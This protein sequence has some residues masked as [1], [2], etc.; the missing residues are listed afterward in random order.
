QLQ[1]GQV[2]ENVTVNETTTPVQTSS[3]AQAGTITGTQVRELELNNRNF[4]QLV[5]LQPGVTSGLPD[6]V[7]F[8]ISNTSSVAV[9]G[10]RTGA[11][12]WTV[13][14][15]D[16]NDSGSNLTLLN[17]PSVDAIQEFTLQRSTYDAQYGRSGG[18]QILV[19][20]KS[21]TSEFHGDAYEFVR[22]DYFNANDFFANSAGTPRAPE[23]YNN[24]GFTIGGPLFVPK[25]YKKSES[26]TFFFWSEEWR[27]EHLPSTYVLNVPTAAELAGSFPG[28]T[29]N[30][31]SAPAGC[32]TNT[33]AGGQINPACFSH[34]ATAYIANVY[35]KFPANA[36]GGN[37]YITNV[38]GLNNYRQDLV[39]LDQNISDKVHIFGRF[40]QDRVPTT[41]P[42]GL[43]AGAGFPGI[44]STATNAPGK[45]VV[46]NVSWTLSP[47]VVN[48]T[49]F[50]YSW[51]AINSNI[52][53]IINSPAFVS[54]LSGGL[55]YGDPYGRI[56]GLTLSGFTGVGIPVSP[57]FERNIDK[58]LF[59]NFSKVLGSHAIR[60]GISVQWMA[61]T[62]NA[63]N[64]TNGSF[65]FNRG[66]G[67]PAF[68]NFLL[69]NASL[70]SQS[71]RDIIPHLNYFNLEAYIQD[72]WKVTRKLTLNL[73][74]RY[75]FFPAPSDSNNVLNNFDP[76]LFNPAL[77][78]AI[79]PA[80][81]N[82]LPGQ[83][84]I[85]ATYTNGII[86]P[87]GAACTAAKAISSGVTCSPYGKLVNPNSN[88]NFGP[89]I[90]F[91]WD[92]T[93]KGKTAIRAGYGLYFDRT[94][95]G[96]WE[97]NAFSDPPLV[98]QVQ[99]VNT[100]FDRPT[101]GVVSVPLGPVSITATGSPTFKVPSYQDWNFSVQQQILPNTTFEIAYV[102]SK[103]THLLGEVDANQPPLALRV[104]DA[105]ANV[106]AIRP[107]LG[108]AAF[109]Q[110]DP[111]FNSNYNSLQ[112]SLNRHVTEGLTLGIA[113]TWSRNLTNNTAD[114]FA[115]IY[116]TYNAGLDYGPAYLNTPHIF[117]ANY[118]Y[119]LPFFRDQRGFIGHVLGG[120]E[121]SGITTVQ[122]GSSLTI[123]QFSDPFNSFD[124]GVPGTYPGGIGI[125]YNSFL[126]PRADVVPGA[127]V[128][129][130]GT[131]AQWM[132]T[133]AFTD[134][135][136]HF[137]TAGPGLILGPGE[138]N[139]DL[140][141]I[142]NFKFTERFRLQ[143]RGEFFNAFN[144]VNF[145]SVETNI[146]RSTFGTLNGDHLPR[147]IQLG[148]KLY[149]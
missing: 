137:G 56:P 125:D 108:Y 83:A 126:A 38:V 97:Q 103:G 31:A 148:A 54:A 140:A 128:T 68:A 119:Q 11:N 52:T 30:P 29:L 104:A 96:I 116:D 135:V 17:V 89:R 61:K 79:D 2:T 14:G 10:A 16:V 109:Y 46:A 33:A 139:W 107:Y 76:L 84:V 57:Y 39:R 85:P 123:T 20:T 145:N 70:F 94:L 22:N 138:Q 44:S 45:N 73:G 118:V 53:G 88:N 114:R 115:P 9:N 6:I 19:A 99:I 69:G 95:N 86:F 25:L 127:S 64:P 147:N 4:E 75:S 43:F 129:G 74:M 120:W 21:G 101:A 113:Y 13:D 26:K 133:K 80:T 36:A 122:S 32:I 24:F 55:P 87:T 60:A 1:P 5:T 27:K 23:R 50:N 141:A 131:V 62:E 82:F 40:M 65:T 72:D 98:Q 130:A 15:A 142:R 134:A 71:S 3:A 93:G 35:S 58:N 102:G 143:F 28:V 146:D 63:V 66:N 12:N 41:E 106:N 37:E 18:G 90:G 7:G 112:V 111:G 149:F 81:G 78:P 121:L 67:N 136:G 49:A 42:G 51:G 124:W 77:V 8:G 92:P 100:S 48:E 132:N 110:R 144:H 105:A 59:D 117:I 34:N 47:T 91:A